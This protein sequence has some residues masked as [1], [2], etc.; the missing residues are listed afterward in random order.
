MSLQSPNTYRPLL[1]VDDDDAFAQVLATALGR[2]GFTVQRADSLQA[3]Q[4]LLPMLQATHA[5]IDLRLGDGNGLDLVP[6]LLQRHPD[7]RIVVLSGYAS[8]PT[9][10]D[11][12]KLGA[13]YYLA[14][15]VDTAAV[16]RAFDGNPTPAQPSPPPLQPPSLRRIEWEHIQ[17]VLRDCQGNVSAAARALRMHRRTL[18]RKLGKRSGGL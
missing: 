4:A 5:V 13:T 17:R 8:I 14:K 18:Q 11:A 2:H 9:A 3:A 15:P 7:M 16:V 6:Q 1:L 12:I 10:I